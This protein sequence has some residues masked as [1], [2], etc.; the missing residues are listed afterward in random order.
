LIAIGEQCRQEAKLR[1]QLLGWWLP[2]AAAVVVVAVWL[3]LR[4]GWPFAVVTLGSLVVFHRYHRYKLVQAFATHP[5]YRIGVIGDPRAIARGHRQSH[6]LMFPVELAVTH[7]AQLYEQP[8]LVAVDER[9]LCWL[10]G[11]IVERLEEGE[12][13][14]IV[15]VPGEGVVAIGRGREVLVSAALPLSPELAESVTRVRVGRR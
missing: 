1:R 5:H 7:E 11:G 8:K 9:V 3:V 10:E 12:R 6:G 15:Q 14:G 4:L 13:I 2:A